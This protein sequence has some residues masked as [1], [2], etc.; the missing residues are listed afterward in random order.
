ME[1]ECVIMTKYKKNIVRIMFI[2]LGVLCLTGCKKDSKAYAYD[3]YYTNGET[4]KLVTVSYG[5][6]QTD[7][8]SLVAELMDQMNTEQKSDNINV[9]KKDNVSIENY[10]LNNRTISIYFGQEYSNMDA[11]RQAIYRCAVVKTLTQIDT[12]EHVMFYVN[13]QPATYSDGTQI[14]MMAESDFI[15]DTASN[16]SNLQWS[17]L[18]LYFASP[19]GDKLVRDNVTVAYSR[20]ISIERVIV[21]QLI[22]GPDNSAYDSTLPEN[23]KLLNITVKDGTCY[24]NLD[25]TFLTEIVNVSSS[26]PIYS[27]VNSLCELDNIDKVQIL[28]NGEPK[29]VYRESISLEFPFEMNTQIIS[30]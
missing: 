2:L 4:N 23:L 16:L 25:S 15:D 3:I 26:V 24:V 11:A 17:N 9:I 22:A 7:P 14:G 20:T 8:L 30:Q 13:N 19:N 29:K 21:E 10:V 18:A 6:D 5:T 1:S 28:I 12:I 27:I